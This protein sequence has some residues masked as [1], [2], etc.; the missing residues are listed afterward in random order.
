MEQRALSIIVEI[1]NQ[2]GTKP[3]NE[4]E[5]EDLTKTGP[6]RIEEKMAEQF[7]KGN[8]LRCEVTQS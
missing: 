3:W 7:D 6:A 5:S 1:R 2:E 4:L 8:L